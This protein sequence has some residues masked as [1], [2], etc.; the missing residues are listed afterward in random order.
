MTKTAW[1]WITGIAIGCAGILVVSAL[2]GGVGYLFVRDVIQRAD[3]MARLQEE[4]QSEHGGIDDYV[5]AIDGSIPADRMR[6]FLHVREYSAA[7]RDRL[8]SSFDNI[9]ADLNNVQQGGG[10]LS[11]VRLFGRGVDVVPHFTEFYTARSQALLETRM[12]LGEYFYI[13]STAYYSFLDKPLED[14]PG[15]L[16]VRDDGGRHQV[17]SEEVPLLRREQ[18]LKRIHRVVLR[19]FENGSTGARGPWRA[20]LEQEMA[21]LQKDSERIPWEDG[22]PAVLASSLEPFRS[23]LERQYLS[24]TNPLELTPD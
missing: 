18:I 8:A 13:Y 17:P 7:V 1:N 14:G 2:I 9:A 15:V 21:L 6:A 23:D 10:F 3:E 12:G 5:P 24:L 19:A 22:V 16:L 20:L 11:V 4:V